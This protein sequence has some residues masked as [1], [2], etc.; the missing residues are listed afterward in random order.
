MRTECSTVGRLASCGGGAMPTATTRAR[1]PS[2]SRAGAHL[3][4][5]ARRLHH[6]PEL[7]GQLVH[8]VRELAAGERLAQR[9]QNRRDVVLPLRLAHAG[10]LCHPALELVEAEVLRVWGTRLEDLLQLL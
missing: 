5:P 9:R 4:T 10:A 8:H 2:A 6:L 3:A 7:V 1:R